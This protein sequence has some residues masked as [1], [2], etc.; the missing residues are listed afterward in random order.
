MVHS[1]FIAFNCLKVFGNSTI[2]RALQEDQDCT[3]PPSFDLEERT[4]DK[5][6]RFQKGQ[7]N[8]KKTP[9]FLPVIPLLPTKL[10]LDKLKDKAAYIMFRLQV[11]KGF[12]PGTPTYRKSIRTFEEGDPQQWM[13]VIT[14]LKEIWAQNSIMA[15]TDMSNT[16]VALLKG[17]SLVSYEASAMEDNC[18]NPVRTN[19]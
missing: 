8:T 5:E 19:L 4:E 1:K 16:M 3:I 7:V 18:A 13:E 2:W 6:M 12:G 15:L 10:L 17:D 11:S 9:K 14:G